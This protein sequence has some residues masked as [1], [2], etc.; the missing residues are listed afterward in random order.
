MVL[1][2]RRGADN[3]PQLLQTYELTSHSD[4]KTIFRQSREKPHKYVDKTTYKK[5]RTHL[6]CIRYIPTFNNRVDQNVNMK[7]I[8]WN[9]VKQT[10]EEA[11]TPHHRNLIQHLRPRTD[12]GSFHPHEGFMTSGSCF[13]SKRSRTFLN[14]VFVILPQYHVFFSQ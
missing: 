11:P 4:A 9:S 14:D 12:L 1:S 13:H 6:K 5:L 7:R 2:P 3:D 10:G 8:I